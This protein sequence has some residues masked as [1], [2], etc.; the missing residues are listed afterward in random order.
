MSAL[1]KSDLVHIA[2]DYDHGMTAT[3][4]FAGRAGARS[5]VVMYYGRYKTLD[6]TRMECEV[7]P[8]LG[9]GSMV[10]LLCPRCQNSLRIS[11][12]NKRIDFD[13]RTGRLS[14]EPFTCT[15]EMD[16]GNTNRRMEFGISLC[17]TKLAIDNNV[18]RDV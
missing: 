4:N 13:P 10:N 7:Y 5:A 3:H 18:A 17:N 9:E 11:G 1:P 16:W 15:W 2:G 14:V 8:D 12:K 6:G